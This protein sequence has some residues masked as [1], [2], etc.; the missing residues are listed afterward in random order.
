MR[1]ERA[2]M[3]KRRIKKTWKQHLSQARQ[4]SSVKPALWIAR[5]KDCPKFKTSLVYIVRIRPARI[6]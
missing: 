4:H 5:Q 1:M 2:D 3:N 6:T